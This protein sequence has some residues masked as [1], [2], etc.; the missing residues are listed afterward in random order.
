MTS[1]WIINGEINSARYSE[2]DSLIKLMDEKN[3]EHSICDYQNSVKDNLKD[4]HFIEL[5][6]PWI[7]IFT[8][9]DNTQTA[10]LFCYQK[11]SFFISY[12]YDS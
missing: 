6:Q 9:L 8:E 12:K 4:N 1:P 7:R 11:V 10:V 5:M 3:V 2:I